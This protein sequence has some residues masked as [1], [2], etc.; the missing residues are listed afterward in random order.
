MEV[1]QRLLAELDANGQK[2]SAQISEIDLSDPA[3]ARVLMPEANGEL[4]AHFGQENFLERYQHYK[5]HINEWEQQ[6]PKL[7]T[8][9]LRYDQQVVLGMD[10]GSDAAQG[11]DNGQTA[12]EQAAKPPSGMKT[13]ATK[14]T[15]S[16][17]N[18]AQRTA[19]SRNKKRA[20][21]QRAAQKINRRKSAPATRPASSAGQGQ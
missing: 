11:A 20:E 2:L 17:A 5:A 19:K 21:I 8:V 16:K 4:L 3:D 10:T 1:Y 15:H 12:D 13:T 18:T 14:N 6:Y 9:D 7:A